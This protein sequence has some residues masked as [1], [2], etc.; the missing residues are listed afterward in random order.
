MNPLK[1]LRRLVDDPIYEPGELYNRLGKPNLTM[2][3][4]ISAAIVIVAAVI[5]PLFLGLF[6]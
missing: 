2:G 1:D 4:L 6:V 3:V 5:V